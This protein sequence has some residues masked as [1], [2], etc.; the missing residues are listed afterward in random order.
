MTG[1]LAAEPVTATGVRA[2]RLSVGF[3]SRGF[4]L[5]GIG[6]LWLIPALVDRRAVWGL[7]AWDALVLLL[8]ASDVRRLP[9]PAALRVTRRWAEALALGRPATVT[10]TIAHDAPITLDAEIADS[11]S[12]ALR[13]DV[14]VVDMT[15]GRGREGEGTYEVRPGER[16]DTTLGPVTVRCTTPWRIATRWARVPLAQTV[17]VYP[18]FHAAQKHVLHLVRSQTLV[19]ERRRA[20]QHGTGR[21]FERLRD[22]REGD[23][24]RDVCWTATARR[25]KLVTR[26]YRPERSQTVWIL[27]DGSRLLRARAGDRTKLDAAVDAALALAHVAHASGDRVGLVTY[28]R[29]VGA[30]LSPDRGGR[31]LRRVMDVLAQA[32]AE[33]VEGDHA[34]AAAALLGQQQRRSLIVWLTDLAETAGVPD[35]IECASQMASRHLVLCAMLRQMD[36]AALAAATPGSATEMYRV[37]AAQEVLDRRE[38][39]LR[40]LRRR[41]ALALD[42][43]PQDVA[44]EVVQRYLAIKERSAL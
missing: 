35:V 30:R 15:V 4:W 41:G 37:L 16:G 20:R 28:G 18:D 9:P 11:P 25:G 24:R 5:L 44:S 1:R 3:A 27:V 26:L 36:V 38:T 43:A 13:R 19:A 7:A 42:L 40:G 33:A 12:T 29:R 22:W 23:E 14:P 31:H 17:R 32:R 10:L 8:W 2:H 6:L 34:A 39:L 21:E